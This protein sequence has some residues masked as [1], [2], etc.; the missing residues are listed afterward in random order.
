METLYNENIGKMDR[1]T[2]AVLG[3]MLVV[4]SALILVLSP[5]MI[6]SLCLLAVYPLMT[7][8]IGWD[9]LIAAA[10]WITHRVRFSVARPVHS[11]RV[12]RI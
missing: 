4:G 6:A 3:F 2:R 8:L 1:I 5:A 10:T 12:A 7:A 9:P 11:S